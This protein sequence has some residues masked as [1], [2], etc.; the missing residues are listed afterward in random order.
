MIRFSAVAMV[1]VAVLSTVFGASYPDQVGPPIPGLAMD[2]PAELRQLYRNPDGSC[3]QC[4]IAMCG[5]DQNVPQ[6]ST[7]LWTTGYGPAE[8]GGSW[9]QRVAAYSAARGIRIYNVT[10]S[11][12]W[13]WM[14]WAARNGRGCA[15]GADYAHFQTLMGH[16][17]QTGTYYVC[18]NNS[19]QRVGEYTEDEFRRLH[20]ASGQWCV[21]LDYPPH[22]ARPVYR[23]WW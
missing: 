22:P 19:P 21:I 20:L 9:P 14:K 17:P 16:D 13:E 2:L 5:H 8:R 1:L 7:L 23:K 10:G 11:S 18:N 3:V 6:A 4:S 12:T 15:I